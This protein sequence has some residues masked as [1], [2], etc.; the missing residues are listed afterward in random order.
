[1]TVQGKCVHCVQNFPKQTNREDNIGSSG[2]WNVTSSLTDQLSPGKRRVPNTK[3][4]ISVITTDWRRKAVKM[5]EAE[6]LERIPPYHCP[7]MPVKA[8]IPR[9][10]WGEHLTKFGMT[11]VTVS[12]V[13][14]CILS[15]ACE[16]MW[17]CGC[18]YGS[19]QKSQG[20]SEGR[21]ESSVQIHCSNQV[22]VKIS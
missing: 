15:G 1:M 21:R 10:N 14:L 18:C 13:L 11:L 9:E 8:A 22:T 4:T 5:A 20:I 2:C 17:N 3:K 16:Y 7:I 12:V 6:L 19:G